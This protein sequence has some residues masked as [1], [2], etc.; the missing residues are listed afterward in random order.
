M[1][2]DTRSAASLLFWCSGTSTKLWMKI[3]ESLMSVSTYLQRLRSCKTN[4]N[5]I[6]GCR[7]VFDSQK[8]CC[9]WF[10]KTRRYNCKLSEW[11]FLD[12]HCWSN[13]FTPFAN[14]PLSLI[15]RVSSVDLFLFMIEK[16]SDVTR[17]RCNKKELVLFRSTLPRWLTRQWGSSLCSE[18][19]EVEFFRILV[20]VY[21]H[22]KRSREPWITM[23]KILR[24]HFIVLVS[25]FERTRCS[26]SAQLEIVSVPL[27]F[28]RLLISYRTLFYRSVHVSIRR[29]VPNGEFCAIISR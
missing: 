22:I 3:S 6:L 21:R 23:N 1:T 12:R 14:R 20:R 18:T 24:R 9:L 17:H 13:L 5:S 15:H 11:D 8:K 4:Q 2:K 16:W 25:K 19:Q 26:T 29:L 10:Y 7:L 28:Q 27:N